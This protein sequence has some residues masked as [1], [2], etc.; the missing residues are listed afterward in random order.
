MQII[1]RF[2]PEKSPHFGGI[3][4]FNVK[5]VKTHLKRIVSPVRLTFEEFTTVLTQVEAVL[6][7]RPL[8]PS[9]CPDDDGISVLTPG[10]FLIGRPLTSLPDPQASYR[11]VSLL[12]RW[13]LYQNLSR[14]FWERW[15]KEYLCILNKHNKWQFP[16]RNAAVGDVVILQ[17]R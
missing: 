7:S 16:T 2:I 9:G 1:W 13:H 10:H 12:K 17:E 8:T 15:S 5:S 6:N 3:W 11:T 4:E 14:H